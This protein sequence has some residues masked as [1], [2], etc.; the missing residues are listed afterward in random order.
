M[1]TLPFRAAIAA[2]PGLAVAG[3]VWGGV[4]VPAC[5]ATATSAATG[6]LAR[7]G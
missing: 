1:K 7:L 6:L 5:V 2:E 4:G 3:S